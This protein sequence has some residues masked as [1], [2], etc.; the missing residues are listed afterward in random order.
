[1]FEVFFVYTVSWQRIRNANRGKF[2][3]F[4]DTKKNLSFKKFK[5]DI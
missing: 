3:K 4:C 2:V 5:Y 1:M